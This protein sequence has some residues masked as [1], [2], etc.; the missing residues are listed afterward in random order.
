MTALGRISSHYYIKYPS[1]AVYNE[2]LK[3]NMGLIEL[4]KVFSLSHEFKYIPIRDEE[5]GEVQKLMESVPVPIKGS[6]EDPPTKMNILLQAYIGRL[7]LN[8]FAMNA[9]MVYAT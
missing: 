3:A 5:K 8:G 4:L 7:S 6:P 9:D 1:I 2:H